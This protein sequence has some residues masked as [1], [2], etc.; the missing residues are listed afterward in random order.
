[1]QKVQTDPGLFTARDPF[2][3]HLMQALRFKRA[4]LPR[5][6]SPTGNNRL[7][8]GRPFKRKQ[9]QADPPAP[10][11][12]ARSSLRPGPIV[13]EMDTFLTK[14]PFAPCGLALRRASTK[15]F[16]SPAI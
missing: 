9:N 14:V 10:V 4:F 1:S 5:R 15:P 11:T 2:D 6:Q 12:L 16:P 7:Q 8:D 3:T 13:D